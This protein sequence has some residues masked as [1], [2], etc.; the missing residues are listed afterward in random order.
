MRGISISI[1]NYSSIIEILKLKDIQIIL[2]KPYNKIKIN[3]AYY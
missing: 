2:D 1:Q 3:S